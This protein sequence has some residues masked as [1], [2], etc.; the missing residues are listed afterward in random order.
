VSRTASEEPARVLERRRRVLLAQHYRQ[1]GES[2]ATIAQRLLCRPAAVKAYLYDP[3]GERSR[4]RK[5]SYQGRCIV[6]G[7]PTSGGDGKTR[8]RRYCQHHQGE[9]RR[10][11]TRER[12]LE[13]ILAW[14][15]RYGTP[16]SSYDWSRTHAR[17][18]GGE[19]LQRLQDA[20]WPSPRT[21]T[22][23]YGTWAAA[24]THAAQHHGT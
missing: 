2:I 19:A 3:T 10:T 23:L 5:R 8:A 16:P 4:E 7:S 11:W 6:C 15:A 20:D 14:Q 1:Q 12:I 24:I 22:R 17:R 18:K 21:V 13:A 9:A